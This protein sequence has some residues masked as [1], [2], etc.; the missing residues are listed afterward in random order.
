V[1]RDRVNDALRECC[2]VAAITQQKTSTVLLRDLVD[3]ATHV[4]VDDFRT[5][6]DSPARSLGQ[7]VVG[8]SVELHARRLIELVGAREVERARCLAQNRV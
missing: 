8:V 2:R 3:R 7:W 1:S 5:M 6:I 4:D